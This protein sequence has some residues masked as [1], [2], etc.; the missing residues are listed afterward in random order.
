MSEHKALSNS[1]RFRQ[2]IA[3]AGP[4]S[5]GSETALV[6]AGATTIRLN[7]SHL[8]PD[9]V[10]DHLQR[11]LAISPEVCC[12]V[13]LQGAKMRLSH[14]DPRSVRAGDSVRF[15][16]DPEVPDA[17]YVPH[18]ELFAQ[19]APGEALSVDDGK[20]KLHVTERSETTLSALSE[21]DYVIRPRKGINCSSHPVDLADLGAGDRAVLDLCR[22]LSRVSYAVSFATDGRETAWV[23][24]RIPRAKVT[25]KVER[26]EALAALQ[27]LAHSADDLWICRGDLGAQ[28]GHLS[29]GHAV[30]AI[31]PQAYGVPLLM[32]GQVLEH[33]TCHEEPTR[34]EICHV[35]D[36]L[37]RGYAGIVLSDETA[38]GVSPPNATRWA[39][40]LLSD[41]SA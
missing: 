35:H 2:L 6:E 34:S 8:A 22:N 21:Q 11:I 27:E 7:A 9:D 40:R 15:S 1:G 10:F 30:A 3:T 38:M 25:L 31:D 12:V 24:K 5:F 28:L 16:C 13:D 18:L 17:L 4:K 32:A 26:R 14:R 37:S 23:K 41:A 19:V 20:L 33:L 36:L 29:L 39:R